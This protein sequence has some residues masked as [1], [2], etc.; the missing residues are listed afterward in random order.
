MCS[1]D[2]PRLD[3]AGVHLDAFGDSKERLSEI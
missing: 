3:K 1:L 2:L